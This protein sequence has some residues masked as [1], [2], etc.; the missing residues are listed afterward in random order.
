MRVVCA[1]LLVFA[2]VT[3]GNPGPETMLDLLNED[4]SFTTFIRACQELGLDDTLNDPDTD[5]LT[6]FAPTDA[7]FAALGSVDEIL[8]SENLETLLH[9]H[10]DLDPEYGPKMVADLSKLKVVASIF[11]SNFTLGLGPNG[12]G[13][14]ADVMMVGSATIVVPDLSANNG[15]VHG[16]DTVLTPAD[17]AL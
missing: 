3:N 14:S 2:V 9:N 11:G 13:E 4:G 1:C 6:V 5:P 17:F 12:S 8:A 16:I 10:I 7:A 15:I